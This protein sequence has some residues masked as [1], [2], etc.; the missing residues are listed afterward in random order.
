MRRKDNNYVILCLMRDASR[1]SNDFSP[2]LRCLATFPICR[3]V[4]I[5]N[6]RI[7]L[8][9]TATTTPAGTLAAILPRL[10]IYTNTEIQIEIYQE[11]NYTR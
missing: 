9:K 6:I 2:L 4:F 7:L 1:Q 5:R 10:A 11:S 3:C 8:S